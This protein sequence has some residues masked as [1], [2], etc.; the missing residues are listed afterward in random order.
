MVAKLAVTAALLTLG[1]A[2][3]PVFLSSDDLQ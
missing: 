1:Q 2:L 3:S